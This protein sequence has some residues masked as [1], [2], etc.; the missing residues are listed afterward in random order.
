MVEN[1]LIL[2]KSARLLFWMMVSVLFP[3]SNT[4]NP[5]VSV[6]LSIAGITYSST[7]S[8]NI[9][10]FSWFI[11][12]VFKMDV[13]TY[14]LTFKLLYMHCYFY[15]V[16]CRDFTSSHLLLLWQLNFSVMSFTKHILN[17]DENM[18]SFL[19]KL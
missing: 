16:I 2:S 8:G 12:P 3:T 19:L 6:T 7:Y 5:H 13:G 18:I 15:W 4:P 10:T 14:L 1:S 17:C 9:L 11:F